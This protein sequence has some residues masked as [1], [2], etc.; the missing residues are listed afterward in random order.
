MTAITRSADEEAI[1]DLNFYLYDSDGAVVL[2]GYQTVPNLRFECLPGVYRLRLAANLGE[3]LGPKADLEA[4]TIDHAD[5]YDVLPMTYEDEIEI[6]ASAGGVVAL[7]TIEVKRRVAKISCNIAVKPA[8]IELKSV[9]VCSVPKSALLFAKDDTPSDSSADYTNSPETILSGQQ[10][11]VDFYMLPNLQGTVA[12]ITDQRQKNA[13]NA[14][15]GASYLLIRA[16]QGDKVLAYSIYLGE[17]NTSDFNVRANAHYRL[18]ISILGDNEVDTRIAAYT[19]SVYDNFEEYNIGGYCVYDPSQ[20]L[21]VNVT[22]NERIPTLSGH[23]EIKAGDADNLGFNYGEYGS[24]HDFELYDVPGENVYEMNYYVPG[25]TNANSRLA[26]R[27]TLTDA[28]GFS[29]PYDFEHRMANAV[30]IH[31][32]VGGSIIV[33]KSLYSLTESMG[34]RTTVLCL[35]EGCRFTAIPASGNTFEGW[36]ADA[37]YTIKLS[38]AASHSYIPNAPVRHLYARFRATDVP[39]DNQGTANCYIAPTLGKRYSFDATTMGNGKATL[40]VTPRRLSGTAARVIWET[41]SNAGA[42][43][44][45][46]EYANGRISFTT[47]TTRGNA[48]IGLFD[49][50]GTCIWSWHIWSVDYYPVNSAQTYFSGAVFMDRNL[51][52][53]TIDCTKPAS[54]GLYYQ[55]GRKDPLIYPETCN[56][57]TRAE[58]VYAAGFE[59]AVSYPENSGTESPYDVMTLEW[60]IRHPT[61]YMNGVF[62]EDWDEWTSVADWLHIPHPNLW[63]NTTTSKNNISRISQKSIYDP[64]PVGWKIPS[65]EDFLGIERVSQSLPYYVT[66]HYN[67]NRTTNIPLGGMFTEGRYT[68]AGQSGC[69]HSNSPVHFRWESQYSLFDGITCAAVGF[70]TGTLPPFIGASAYY[71]YAANPVRCI[72]E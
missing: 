65:V 11:A 2:H 45:S 26:Y 59:Y 70:S 54:R 47:G 42:V 29:Q 24:E 72:R 48:V 64:C 44:E 9:R 18:N 28:Y 46:V 67:G 1:H 25:Y 5:A 43:I 68:G 12:S 62:Y 71:R 41:G 17:N 56:G 30:Y 27:V 51:G 21:Y 15:D 33:D 16:T 53:L 69:L 31:T 50:A 57:N 7:P 22:G 32:N 14:P 10:A 3:D 20:N 55:W 60:S 8:D 6:P 40:N 63:G 35:E 38:T 23:L 19:L 34:K 61:T 4:C 66:I 52:A 37:E 36:Y 49:A 13:A 58:A 39:L